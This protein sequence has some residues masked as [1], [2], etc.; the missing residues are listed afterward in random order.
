MAETDLGIAY[1]V[2]DLGPRWQPKLVTAK[3]ISIGETH[4]WIEQEI[5][6]TRWDHKVPVSRL[7]R[8]PSEALTRYRQEWTRNREARK[9]DVENAEGRVEWALAELAKSGS[10]GLPG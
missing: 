2:E 9:L 4:F 8:T 6:A 3:I 10:D 5:P 1:F 7:D